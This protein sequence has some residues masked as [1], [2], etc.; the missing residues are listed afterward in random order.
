MSMEFCI[1]IQQMK[2]HVTF[3]SSVIALNWEENFVAIFLSP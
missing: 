1:V 2:S 3:G